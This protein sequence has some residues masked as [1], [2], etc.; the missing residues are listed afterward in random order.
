MVSS[1]EDL[2]IYWRRQLAKQ[3]LTKVPG[4]KYGTDETQKMW[5]VLLGTGAEES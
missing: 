2:V 5:T 4:Q 3:I 1:L